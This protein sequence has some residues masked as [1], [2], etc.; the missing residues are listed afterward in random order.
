MRITVAVSGGADS[1]FTLLRMQESGCEVRAVHALFADTP[2]ARAAISKVESM[3]S[4]LGIKLELFDLRKAFYEQVIEPF[5]AEHVAAHTPNPCSICNRAMKFGVLL[6][7]ILPDLSKIPGDNYLATGHY[8]RLDD[9]PAYGKTLRAGVDKEKDQSY[10]LALVPRARLRA[11]LFPLG[12]Q[13]KADILA[14][15]AASGHTPP[16][17]GESQEICFI[18]DNNHLSFLEKAQMPGP[19]PILLYNPPDLPDSPRALG[20]QPA[21]QLDGQQ[22]GI[23]KGLWRYTEGQR[24]GLGVTWRE[25][26]FVIARDPV[27][28]ALIVAQRSRAI[29]TGCFAHS[30]NFFVAPQ[31]WPPELLVRTRYRH[32]ATPARVEVQGERLQIIHST[33]Q[34]PVAPGQVAAIYDSAGFLLAGGILE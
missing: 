23:H 4:A 20:P 30:V 22:I 6:E 14:N 32:L 27:R 17:P 28:N 5:I 8:V 31:M 21:A 2:N 33:P 19:G 7:Q 3:C 18:P 11:Y 16:L 12:G 13:V 34:D 10:F 9:H 25:P 1:L 26:L 24:K 15:L 29:Q